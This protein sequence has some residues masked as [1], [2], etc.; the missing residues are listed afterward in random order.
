LIN[1]EIGIAAGAKKGIK[2]R[3]R[4]KIYLG[5]S[6]TNAMVVFMEHHRLEPGQTGLAQ[7]RLL[8][9]VAAR[10]RDAFVISPL[11]IN[12]VIGGG[13]VLETPREKFRAAKSK[14]V[15]PLLAALQKGDVNAYVEK[16]FEGAKGSLISA[17]TLCKKT[18]LP[19]AP[20]ERII[21]SKVQK[22]E[23]VYIKGR[24]A[25]EKRHLTLL[26]K[27][28]KTAIEEVFS[29]DPLK[30]SVGILEVAEHMEH[31]V[32]SALLKITADALCT[33]GDIIRVDGGYRP[34]GRQPSL[35]ACQDP[36][37][38]FLLDYMQGTGLTPISP[39]FFWKHHQS[40]Y[41]RGKAVRL[42][43]YLYSQKKLI[44]LNDNRFL[45]IKA[46][47]EIKRR[48]AR[49]IA[50]RGFIT[51][52]DCKELFGYG[53]SGG[54]HVLDYLNQTGFTVRRENKHYLNEDGPR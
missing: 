33:N 36:Q 8:K 51:L 38:S 45:S 7:I 52:T 42:F 3:Q 25:I 16:I 32:E 4:V 20:F 43:N 5:T 14:S 49:A 18:G 48:V 47:E 37:V 9:P 54:T 31:S 46:V 12:T 40:Q 34:A 15:L 19:P 24:G 50:D 21:N 11:N 1:A 13:R 29:K 6:I 28:F 41:G 17:K 26:D 27:E 35:H 30:K 53:R 2:N 10:P 39:G 44:R 23:F 22:G